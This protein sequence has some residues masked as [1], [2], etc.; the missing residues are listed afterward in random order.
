[1]K[2]HP[3][4]VG[5]NHQFHVDFPPWIHADPTKFQ[6]QCSPASTSKTMRRHRGEPLGRWACRFKGPIDWGR[7][8][9]TIW[10]TFRW[11][12]LPDLCYII[13]DISSYMYVNVY[14]Y[15]Y[16]Y[17][18]FRWIDMFSSH[19]PHG[20]LTC[21]P[22]LG[23]PFAVNAENYFIRGAY[24][25]WKYREKTLTIT[26]HYIIY[27]YILYILLYILYNILSIYNIV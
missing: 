2:N 1:M 4:G 22:T 21:L 12:L 23:S 25:P 16:W 11:D 24:R 27:I 13:I 19:V 7:W 20:A 8:G 5:W 17:L 14:I 15:V 6:G 26:V 10:R 3:F 18:L 9:L